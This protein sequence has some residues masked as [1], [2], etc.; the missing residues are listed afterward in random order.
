MHSWLSGRARG[1]LMVAQSPAGGLKLVLL[2]RGHC[3]AQS[4]SAQFSHDL[5]EGAL[6][7]EDTPRALSWDKH[8]G[9]LQESWA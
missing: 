2:P 8:R 6:P 7:V 1:A 5:E 4:C 3:W 9:G